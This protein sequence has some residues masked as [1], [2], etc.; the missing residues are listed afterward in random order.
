M[1]NEKEGV[2]EKE[3]LLLRGRS[4]EEGAW[5]FEIRMPCIMVIISICIR[6]GEVSSALQ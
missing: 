6:L 4:L 1:Q 5:D 2:G 3:Q